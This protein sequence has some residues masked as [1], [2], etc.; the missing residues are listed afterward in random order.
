MVRRGSFTRLAAFGLLAAL[1][2]AT[3]SAHAIV[4]GKPVHCLALYGEPKYGPDF[5]NFDYVNPDAPKGGRFVK[6][7]EAYLTYDTFNPYTIKGAAV[8]GLE[9]LLYDTLMVP[10]QDEPATVYALIAQS[11]EVAADNSWVQFTLNPAAKFN[12]GSKITADDVVFSYETLMTKAWP[13]Y[14][15]M[16][17]DVQKAEAV[18]A[19]V[20]RFTFKTKDNLKLPFFLAKY[21]PV[22]SKAYWKDRD[23]MQTTLDV[24]VT[25]GP[26]KI[27]EFEAGRFIVYRRR[28]DYWAKDL[29]V[30]R[31][32]YNFD[33]VRFEYF[34]DDDV[35]FEAFKTS[36]YDFKR[37][38]RAR[39][40]STAYDFPAA[41][42]GR[43]I[44]K[45]VKT[46]MPISTQ[47]IV[48]NLRRP[49]FQ[50]RRVRQAMNYI[51]DFESLNAN[52]FYGKYERLRSYW[53]GSPLEAKG[54]PN[55]DELKLL[56]PFRDKIPTEV[57]TQEFTQPT[58]P[59]KGDIRE[60]LLKARELLTQAGWELR[61]NVLTNAKT[62]QPFSFE[63][64]NHQQGLDAI[65]LPYI[66]NLKRLGIQ[67]S[68]RTVDTSQYINRANAY[69]FDV[70][71]SVVHT[72]LT[73]GNELFAAWGSA[74]ADVEGGD[75]V[76][77][78]KDP[79]VDALIGKITAATTYEDLT[80]ATHALDRVLTWNFYQSLTY[81]N[82]KD[83]YAYWSK[84]KMP[85][86]IPPLGWGNMGEFSDG[87]GE[88]VIALWWA[89]PVAGTPGAVPSGA[90][91][92]KPNSNG[93]W[94]I[95]LLVIAAVGVVVFIVVRRRRAPL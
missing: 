83:W 59:G 29:P 1:S 39:R 79:V 16:Y 53:Q 73:P 36:L 62:G 94:T 75:N 33:E 14:R 88:S 2:L 54:L 24:P 82:G 92:D 91:Q 56:E 55:A 67:V 4:R 26:Y 11:A 95:L 50:D 64:L 51:F 65:F 38:Y 31:G 23:F 72:D 9:L 81:S 12:D 22:L 90:A 68:F 35:Q 15:S 84:M 87:V 78:V 77:G 27:A 49:L 47:Q 58:T 66:E 70:I 37:E 57:F 85:D 34:R 46:I 40:W 5:K 6:T 7:N 76:S 93:T 48:F 20:V 69:D 86:V 32:Q 10:S 52:L 80:T 61:D 18:S 43:V 60:N 42:D 44:K 13:R 19:E 74:A 28:D 41:L 71:Y 45:E 3:H 63:I 25:N 17:D 30:N 8:H 89:D 21:L